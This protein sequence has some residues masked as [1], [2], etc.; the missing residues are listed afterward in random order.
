MT[1][2]GIMIPT[3]HPDVV[4]RGV[5]KLARRPRSIVVPVFL[6]GKL[7][8]WMQP[9]IAPITDRVLGRFGARMQMRNEPVDRP[10]GSLFHPFPQGV[11]PLGSVPPTLRWKR[12]ASGAALFGLA[13][14]ALGMAGLGGARLARAF[15]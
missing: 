10:Q 4:A 9:W 12:L 5:V 6:Q 7:P 8:L 15:R 13:G 11:G 14:G 1:D 2:G 3:Y